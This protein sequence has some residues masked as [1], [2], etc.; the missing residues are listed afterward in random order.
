MF[1][2]EKQPGD[3][4]RPSWASEESKRIMKLVAPT[5]LFSFFISVALTG[6]AIAAAPD[7]GTTAPDFQL[8]TTGGEQ[9]RLSSLRGHVVVLNFFA[10]WCP[11]CRRETPDL[12]AAA[13]RYAHTGV[14]FVGVD[15]REKA[16][17]VQVWAEG[18][19]VR[20]AIAMDSDAVVEEQYDVRAIPTTYVLDKNGVIR[21]RQLDQLEAA[22]LTGALDAVVAGRPLPESPVAQTFDTTAGT[23]LSGVRSALAGG[24]AADAIAIGKKASSKLSD[25]QNGTGSSTI[26]YFKATQESD[27]LALALADAYAARAKTETDS[28][29]NADLAQEAL[30]R[31]QVATDR[32]RYADAYGFYAHA[33][34]LDASTASDAYNGEYLAAVY[35]KQY[36]KG[37]DAAK[38]LTVAVPDDPESWLTLTSADLGA[39]AYPGA[40]DSAGH[41]LS[42]ASAAYAKKPT[43]KSAAYEL[44]RVWLKFGRAELA[45]GN[46]EAA[47]ALLR[48]ASAAAPKTIV[49]E[50]ATEQFAALEPAAIAVS[51]AGASRANAAAATPAKLWVVVRNPSDVSRAVNL[52][53]SGLPAH[54][55]LSFCYAKVCQPYKSTITL[56]AG[57]SMRVE[58]QV[59]PLADSGGPWTMRVATDGGSTVHVRIAAKTANATA[60]VTATSGT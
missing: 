19:G 15:D 22:T 58:L 27:D 55:L 2:S 36:D 56:A 38:A 53:A 13:K 33:V 60:M 32:E 29:A 42:L 10:T 50:Q 16:P 51:V 8:R 5:A 47:M 6:T 40:I 49:A 45:A 37:V 21:Y 1:V 7:V 18:K 11:P 57:A 28:A 59:V 48:N 41:A 30:Q 9:L 52:A 44:G 43:D 17:L 46:S 54:W 24:K 31:G 34:A 4:T 12:V 35:L 14:V 25:L 3:S 20:F 23:A 26:D 39:K